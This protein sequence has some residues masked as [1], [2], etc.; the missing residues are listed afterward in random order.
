V[1]VRSTLDD[2]TGQLQSA[3]TLRIT[4]RLNG[5]SLTEIGTT[6][7][8]PFNAT[9]PCTATASTTV[10]STCSLNTTADAV[11]PGMVPEVKRTIWQ[12]G[13]VRIF[14]GGPDGQ[15]S[16]QDNSL[17]LRQGIFVP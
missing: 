17:F 16:T 9:I 12:M 13:D 8:T 10:G 1:R 15:A 11:I 3:V 5:A 4:D 14:D 6:A 7:D 2:Y